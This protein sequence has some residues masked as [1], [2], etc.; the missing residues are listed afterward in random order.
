[1]SGRKITLRLLLLPIAGLLGAS[2]ALPAPTLSIA[3]GGDMIGP[4]VPQAA[5][6]DP[7]ITAVSNLFRS[8]DLGFANQEGSIFDAATFAGDAASENGGGYPLAPAARA[9]DIS[10]FGIALVSKAN[11]HATDFGTQGLMASLR[12]LAA[13]G[14]P[15]AGAGLNRD[16][17]CSATYVEGRSGTVALISAATTYPPIVADNGLIAIGMSDIGQRG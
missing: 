1:M 7:E 2:T 16:A 12:S 10:A 13:A 4:Y 14:I 15:H 5:T 6:T 8:A 9:N 3:I 11:N 17:A